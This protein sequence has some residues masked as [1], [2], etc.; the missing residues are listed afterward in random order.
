MTLVHLRAVRE[1]PLQHC[2]RII[3]RLLGLMQIVL[4][5]HVQPARHGR[6]Q[7]APQPCCSQAAA[8]AAAAAAQP[9]ARKAT[10]PPP[11]ACVGVGVAQ[12]SAIAATL[13]L[14]GDVIAES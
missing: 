2:P 12:H 14:L 8:A 10:R 3:V 11:R 5:T 1:D 9:R 7:Q 4:A 13:L 6:A